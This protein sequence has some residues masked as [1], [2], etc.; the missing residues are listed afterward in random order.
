MTICWLISDV[1]LTKCQTLVMYQDNPVLALNKGNPV[2]AL[3][4]GNPVL[5]L[6]QGNPVLALYQGNPVLAF[7]IIIIRQPMCPVVGRR[8]QHVVSK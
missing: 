5:A 4:Q 7:I 3:Y 8:P 2:L 6:Y 1:N